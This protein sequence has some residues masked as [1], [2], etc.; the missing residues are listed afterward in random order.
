MGWLVI[1]RFTL[2]EIVR[3]RIFLAVVVL[4][5]LLLGL[6]TLLLNALVDNLQ[7]A[8]P[9]NME[10]LLLGIGALM[11][12]LA[13]WSVYL[14]SSLM[15]LLLTAGMLSGEIEAGTLAVIVPKPLHR[16]EIV[17]GKWLAYAL[18]LAGYTAVL[19]LGFLG[20][21]YWKTGYWP[22]GMAQALGL[23][24][25]GM[26]CLLAL[27]TLGSAS[28][29]TLANGAIAA[30]LFLGTPL[31]SFAQ[32]VTQ[33]TGESTTVERIKTLFELLMPSDALWHAASAALLPPVAQDLIGLH[34]VQNLPIIGAEALTPAMALW[35]ALYIVVLPLLGMLRFARR[36]L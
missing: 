4:T 21:I 2:K 11:A 15:T 5:V 31:A 24:E 18:V 30:L 22:D 25:L 3:R 12:V 6:F 32:V 9:E 10:L 17:F 8:Q 28:L 26:L 23:L 36:D 13:S 27:L 1:A 7:R 29:P 19:E 20:V 14:Q 33:I 16:V 34:Q 35:A